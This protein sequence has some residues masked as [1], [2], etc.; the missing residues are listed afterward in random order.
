MIYVYPHKQHFKAAIPPSIHSFY[1]LRL[2]DS[3]HGAC[4]FGH[5]SPRHAL[6]CFWGG[7]CS[8]PDFPVFLTSYLT[9]CSLGS[10]LSN[11]PQWKLTELT[12]ARC[13]AK[14][15]STYFNYDCDLLI[16]LNFKSDFPQSFCTTPWFIQS[17][18]RGNFSFCQ[19]Q[20]KLWVETS[21]LG[22]SL[23]VHGRPVPSCWISFVLRKYQ[24]VVEFI[25]KL[26][27]GPFWIYLLGFEIPPEKETL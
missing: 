22:V 11:R 9:F 6:C 3:C 5:L 17:H 19:D 10:H 16:D 2:G 27:P 7:T 26:W 15:F 20:E 24:E 23:C 14:V 12:H 4:T 1:K 18:K 13:L 8:N 21:Y 25:F